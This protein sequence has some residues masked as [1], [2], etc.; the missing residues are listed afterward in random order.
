MAGLRAATL[1][2]LVFLSNT[3]LGWAQD[4]TLTSRDGGVTI[5]GTLITYDGEFYRVDTDYGELTVDGTAVICEGPGC[6]DLAAYV[7]EI[8]IAGSRTMGEVL[9]PAMVEAFAS[10]NDYALRRAVN[11]DVEFTYVLTDRATG[12][13]AA[14]IGFRVNSTAEGFADL[15]SGEADIVLATRLAT[16]REIRLAQDAGLGDLDNPR[17]SRIVAL[18]A[19]VP[20]VATANSI[21]GITLPDLARLYSGEI[22]NWQ[23]L[24]GPDAPVALHLR[25]K[26]SGLAFHFTARV[27]TRQ[28]MVLSDEVTRHG[29]NAALADAVARDPTAI[30]IAAWSDLGNARALTI[31]GGCAVRSVADPVALKA[32]D[33]PLTAPLFLYTPARRLPVL[34]REFLRFVRSDAAQPVVDRAGFTD[35]RIQAAPVAN[36]GLRLAQAIGAAGGDVGLEDLQKLVD[37]MQGTARL[38]LGFRFRSGTRLDAQS[39]SN[40]DLLAQQIERGVF[41]GRRLIFVGFSDGEGAPDAN[42]SLARRRAET[43]RDAVLAAAPTADRSRLRIS[44]DAF[45][46]AMPMA[47]DDTEWGRRVNRRVEVWVD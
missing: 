44:T 21:T 24:G 35:L 4:V 31:T 9:M 22:A 41:D 32:E 14:R 16:A 5:S 36:Q 6:P 17:R 13:E 25:D 18:D 19:L 7:A 43:A 1:A 15:L 37:R 42:L 29:S 33:Y 47:C 27:M 38:S 10:Q 12:R 46:E 30:G 39:L 11:S 28:G 40:V 45:G 26:N 2:A 34:V 8:T 23:Q 20:V 3:V